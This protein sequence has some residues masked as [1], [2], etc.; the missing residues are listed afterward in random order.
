MAGFV[1][2]SFQF[3]ICFLHISA[4]ANNSLDMVAT[5][6]RKIAAR[7]SAAQEEA[8]AKQGKAKEAKDKIVSESKSA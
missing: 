5:E 6:E 2:L 4:V 8:S 1:P 7:K 3:L